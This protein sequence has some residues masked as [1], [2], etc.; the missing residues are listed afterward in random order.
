VLGQMTALTGM[1]MDDSFFTEEIP[2]ELGKLTGL[3]SFSLAN[4]QLPGSILTEFGLLTAMTGLYLGSNDLSGDLLSELGSLTTLNKLYV[5]DNQLSGPIPDELCVGQPDLLFCG[6]P[7]SIEL[8]LLTVLGLGRWDYPFPNRKIV[9]PIIF[10]ML[11]IT[12]YITT[13]IIMH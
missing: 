4:N 11:T 13:I 7:S 12:K 1:W 5:D 10:P 9:L 8:Y 2:S 6:L 3:S